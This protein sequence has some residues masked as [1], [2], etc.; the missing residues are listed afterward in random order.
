MFIKQLSPTDSAVN[1]IKPDVQRDAPLGVYWMA[2]PHGRYTLKMMGVPDKYNCASTLAEE[3]QR[4]SKF[5]EDD[6]QYNW[7]IEVDGRVVG[8]IWV[9]LK[10]THGQQAPALSIMIG[11]P[12]VRGG[13]IGYSA[14][15]TIIE[16]LRSIG[17]IHVYSRHLAEN[18]AS[19][20]LLQK[21][22]F[23]NDQEPYVDDEDGLNWQN[24]VLE[25]AP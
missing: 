24:V 13:G 9:D 6:N 15:L 3:T 4:M 16:Y 23:I 19:E 17:H 14:S 7:M 22:H 1:L 21:L 10:P 8:T 25:I 11:D 12:T 5:L 20:K 18:R 2:D